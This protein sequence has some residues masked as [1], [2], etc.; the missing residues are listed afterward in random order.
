MSV[1]QLAALHKRLNEVLAKTTGQR[2]SDL[3]IEIQ[4]YILDTKTIYKSMIDKK[5]PFVWTD[6]GGFKL[7]EAQ[8]KPIAEKVSADLYNLYKKAVKA[9]GA[10]PITRGK[11]FPSDFNSEKKIS[12]AYDDRQRIVYFAGQGSGTDNDQAF[13]TAI[14]R[15]VTSE[16]IANRSPTDWTRVYVEPNKEWMNLSARVR[17]EA[18][19]KALAEGKSK[20]RAGTI[21]RE[22]VGSIRSTNLDW[23]GLDSGHI[24]GPGAR[25]ASLFLE[26]PGDDLDIYDLKLLGVLPRARRLEIQQLI[27]NIIREDTN[28]ELRRS[29]TSSGVTATIVYT[30]PESKTINRKTGGNIQ[31]DITKLRKLALEIQKQIPLGEVEGSPSY[32]QLLVQYIETLFFGKRVSPK[33][34]N[35]RSKVTLKS[36]QTIRIAGISG[37]KGVIQAT[38]RKSGTGLQGSLRTRDIIV[39]INSRFHDKIR[40]NMGQGKARKILNYRTGRFAKSARLRF[41]KP[42]VQKNTL[43]ANVSY[44]RRP[45]GVFEKGSGDSRATGPGRDPATIFGKS[46]RQILQE[47]AIAN[48]AR[49]T[50]QVSDK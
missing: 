40:S 45:Y 2:R 37:A 29:V 14:R 19:D 50:V 24:Y 43:L 10:K 3:N 33:K 48:L 11:P 44:Q 1:S 47:Y 12:V 8:I 5:S 15:N 34:F 9:H 49:V 28:L 7:S 16:I 31:K 42:G 36:K 17:A 41:L 6:K 21:G 38:P 32:E 13:Q 27:V 39:L 23:E 4:G 22:A 26:N 30:A 25:T 35:T 20:D 18:R 46:I